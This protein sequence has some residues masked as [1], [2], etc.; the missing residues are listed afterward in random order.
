MV[1]TERLALLRSQC[2]ATQNIISSCRE[3]LKALN[4]IECAFL[5]YQNGK[6]CIENLILY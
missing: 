4:R 2:L 6:I 1:T 3:K 5:S